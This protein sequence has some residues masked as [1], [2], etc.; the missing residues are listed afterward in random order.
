[1]IVEVVIDGVGLVTGETSVVL[2]LLDG[3]DFDREL[4]AKEKLEVR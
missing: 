2:E 4:A 1:M 3:I